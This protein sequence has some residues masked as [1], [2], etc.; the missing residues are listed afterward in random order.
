MTQRP[1]DPS[2]LAD[3]ERVAK[4]IR[5]LVREG[6]VPNAG[7]ISYRPAGADW[8]WTARHVHIGLDSIGPGDII[9]SDMQG[10]AIDSPWEASGERF[11]Y[12]EIFARRPEVRAIA[13]FHPRMATVFSVVGR[14]LLPVLMLA[15]HI[16]EVPQYEK[17]EPVESA[18]DGQALATALGK[19]KAVLMRSHG[20]VTVGQSVEEVCALAVM[21]E[22]SA[23]TQ[24]QA[25]LIGE[26]RAIE[27]K[28]RE[29]VFA[30]AFKH[31]QDVLWDH[32]NLAKENSP[33]L[34]QG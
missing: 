3:R 18:A 28:G 30:G 5:V 8:F 26:P 6:L 14:R 11:I 17:P 23:R 15:A 20:A 24:Y 32:H 21:L 29:A 22:E 33:F 1:N 9:A 4:G 2:H 12:T 27:T 34:Q 19:A 13:H 16:G 25:S 7:H 31:F 10:R